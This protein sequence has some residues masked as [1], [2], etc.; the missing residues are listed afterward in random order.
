MPPEATVNS[1]SIPNEVYAFTNTDGTGTFPFEVRTSLENQ[2]LGCSATV[3]CTLEVIPIDGINCDNPDP[4]AAC[5]QAGDLAPG[6]GQHRPGPAGR[7]GARRSGRR[8]RTGTAASRC[9]STSPSRRASARVATAGKPVPF[10]GSELLGQAALQ[11]IPAYCLNKKRFNWQDNVM[12]D[13]AAFAPD[14]ERC[15]CRGRGVGPASSATPAASGTRRRPSPAGRSPSTSTRPDNAGQQQSI[16][17]NALLL[18]KLLT[19]SYP[20]STTVAAEQPGLLAQPALA[21]PRPGLHQAQPRAGHHATGRR[22]PRRSWPTS[23]SSQIMFQLTSYIASDPKAMAFINGKPEHDGPVHDAG[24]PGVQGRPAAGGLLGAA[25]H[26]AVQG[27]ARTP[28][29]R[30]RATRCRRTCR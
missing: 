1:V 6:P 29:S 27:R 25:R 21:Q 15:G 24:Q 26:L 18:A 23:T 12:P 17:L 4:G 11:W 7:G 14:A 22:R 3:P 9:R 13:D 5:N 20:G 28:A 8:P 30:R 16:K 10:Y 2:S 19:E